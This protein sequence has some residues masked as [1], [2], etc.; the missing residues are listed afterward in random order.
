M[1]INFKESGDAIVA[2][3]DGNG[4]WVLYNQIDDSANDPLLKIDEDTGETTWMSPPSGGGDVSNPMTEDLDAGGYSVKSVS[5][6]TTQHKPRVDITDPQYGAK[7]DGSTDDTQAIEDAIAAAN[8]DE[9]LY[10]P[11][12]S[13]HYKTTSKIHIPNTLNVIMEGP[14]TL[15][16]DSDSITALE[17]GNIDEISQKELVLSVSKD[18]ISDWTS[19]DS[20]GILLHNPYNANIEIKSAYA[21]TV[22][23]QIRSTNAGAAYSKYH[24]ERIVG[25][26]VGLDLYADGGW[27]NQNTFFGGRFS[28]YSGQ[29]VG[30]ERKGIR[31]HSSTSYLSNNN[32]FI[33]PNFELKEGEADPE[34]AIGIE[35]IDGQRNHVWEARDESNTVGAKF[36]A[37]TEFNFIEWGHGGS[38]S[39]NS[40]NP[41]SNISISSR[42]L[43][44]YFPYCY[45]SENLRDLAC[46]YNGDSEIHV[47]KHSMF[48]YAD[49]NRAIANDGILHPNSIEP[50]GTHGVG[51]SVDTVDS[52]E[53]IL[54]M[55][56]TSDTRP[57]IR[58]FDS[59]G[60]PLTGDDPDDPY[61]LGSGTTTPY[62]N[63]SWH[64]YQPGIDTNQLIFSVKDSVA[65]IDIIMGVGSKIEGYQLLAKSPIQRFNGNDL[66]SR[67]NVAT[68]PP[69]SGT[70]EAGK[71]ILNHDPSTDGRTG[72]I[73]ISG[74]TPGTWSD[75]RYTDAEAV[76]AIESA[77]LDMDSHQIENIDFITF[78]GT[79][80]SIATN[81]GNIRMGWG[82]LID[83]GTINGTDAD[84]IGGYT[85]ADS[86]IEV[87]PS[88]DQTLSADNDWTQIQLDSEG[89]DALDEFYTSTYQ[90]TAEQ[91]GNYTFTA[92]VSFS[93]LAG[94]GD[95]LKIAIYKNGSSYKSY[96][97]VAPDSSN[98]VVQMT[99][100]LNLTEGDTVSLYA[101][102]ISTNNIDTVGLSN[103]TYL[104]GTR[105]SS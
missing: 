57:R 24:L 61:V 3:K 68:T 100:H 33:H 105:V 77:D 41:I 74:G 78:D 79:T 56:G 55:I 43:T 21:F 87:Y 101:A 28:C 67:E 93:N 82:N 62:W 42:D 52:K 18:T 89:K 13:E 12:T 17:I 47:L 25:N 85:D 29:G 80:D 22:G 84:L 72:W 58:P 49:T 48:V 20:I 6:L 1:G 103:W 102:K 53:F 44:P 35:I 96:T 86:F 81:G 40:G 60:D 98:Q 104:T 99:T 45:T 15:Y 31:I 70:F 63:D 88:T 26:K 65:R 11:P 64:A 10:F 38:E 27:V 7:G 23:A 73:C 54:K 5:T 19:E 14:L 9:Y 4:N 90:F 76:A 32:T 37:D 8:E 66:R 39:D 75:I 16:D 97:L 92:Q 51:F 94:V 50:D 30:K 95:Q 59:N 34:D 69:T 2:E 46:Y 36:G 71:I 91:E 83:V